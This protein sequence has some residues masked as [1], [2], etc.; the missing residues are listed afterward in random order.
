M[1]T[2][3]RT[4]NNFKRIG[5]LGA[6]SFLL[7]MGSFVI[8]NI[9]NDT[10]AAT[11]HYEEIPQTEA[12]T[13]GN[14]GALELWGEYG[15]G[16][17]LIGTYYF[18]KSVSPVVVHLDEE[19][20]SLTAVKKYG[21]EVNLDELTIAGVAPTNYEKKLQYT[22][23]D[24]I[25]VEDSIKFNISGVGKLV[26]SA[27]A[28]VSVQGENSAYHFPGKNG[29]YFDYKIGSKLGSFNMNVPD[30]EYLF[31][32][33]YLR[34]AS[35]HPEAPIDWYVAND[36][37]Y[38]YAY[39]EVFGDNTFDHGK[40]FAKIKIKTN[41]GE[42]SY[43]VRTVEANQYGEWAFEY[44]DTDYKYQYQHM[45]YLI[46]VPLADIDGEN[47][48][49]SF[50]YY[51]TLAG[52]LYEYAKFRKVDQNGTP[53]ANAKFKLFIKDIDSYA[54]NS[55]AYVDMATGY[56]GD[57]GDNSSE[58]FNSSETPG[59]EA[60]IAKSD[61]D[62]NVKFAINKSFY[63]SR[64]N[65]TSDK[66]WE[67]YG[68]GVDEIAD[69]ELLSPE[70][71]NEHR[72][73]GGTS[74][75]YCHYNYSVVDVDADGHTFGYYYSVG[76][77]I[78]GQLSRIYVTYE[79]YL[80]DMDDINNIYIRKYSW[81]KTDQKY[82]YSD[83]SGAL[84]AAGYNN[85][86]VATLNELDLELEEIE[87]PTGFVKKDGRTKLVADA[88]KGVDITCHHE[89]FDPT[90]SY[91]GGG[92]SCDFPTFNFTDVVNE[93]VDA[94]GMFA[95]EISSKITNPKPVFRKNDVVQFEVYVTNPETFTIF[96]VEV[97]GRL[98]GARYLKGNKYTLLS[99]DLVSIPSLAPGETLTLYAEY[100]VTEDETAHI[101]NPYEITTAR[102]ENGYSMDTSKDYT[103]VTD[104]DVTK[105]STPNVKNPQTSAMN[106]GIYAGVIVFFGTG[107]LLALRKSRR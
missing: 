51:G 57:C 86:Y 101:E 40:D 43:T 38:L 87:V 39:A 67:K 23:N 44:T 77:D 19:V 24:L 59:E 80:G 78:N 25:E 29:E 7:L 75:R 68:A 1:K 18:G 32:N 26:I 6:I 20:L 15:D 95:P 98:P 89:E 34:P 17:G 85:I 96:D 11:K 31:Y 42:K 63:D 13:S 10:E 102:A 3:K 60:Y 49:M 64:V 69:N 105:D 71:L 55:C 53:I 41:N 33:E 30:K 82:Y 66:L 72:D 97:K 8:A 74:A 99:E 100:V 90:N 56:P 93:K 106:P 16:Y 36:D 35:G 81:S 91:T 47:V 94:G 27:R 46:K 83:G 22:D 103:T 21:Y 54:Y 88:N 61:N 84:E 76:F 2:K 5:V 58:N 37:S 52:P 92:T 28:P 79:K 4:S 73:C 104:F 14:K 107:V 65:A 9:D 45:L 48:K 62:G 70:F 12:I 50:E